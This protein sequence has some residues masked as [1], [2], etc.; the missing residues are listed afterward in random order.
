MGWI[1]QIMEGICKVAIL[2]QG[3]FLKQQTTNLTPVRLAIIR[4]FGPIAMKI[5]L[6]S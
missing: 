2:I 4:L 6:V 1:F 5:Y 3:V